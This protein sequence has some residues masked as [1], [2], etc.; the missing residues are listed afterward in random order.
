MSKHTNEIRSL[1]DPIMLIGA[2]CGAYIKMR[3]YLNRVM[4]KAD[5]GD[6]AAMDLLDLTRKFSKMTRIFIG[7]PE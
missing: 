7:E 6:P 1:L 4:E 3:G 2:D 5:D